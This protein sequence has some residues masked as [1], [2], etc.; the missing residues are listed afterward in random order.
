[1][2]KSMNRGPVMKKFLFL[3]FFSAVLP[4]FAA[5][6]GFKAD[7][8]RPADNIMLKNGAVIQDG[9]LRFFKSRSYAE[10]VESVPYDFRNG[11]TLMMVCRINDLAS[12]PDKYRFLASKGD[13]FLFG[14]TNQKYNF[15]FCH[16]N[17]WSIAL[18]GGTPPKEGEWVHLAAVARRI[19]DKEQGKFG[20]QL[21]LYVN[22]ERILGKFAPCGELNP[23]KTAPIIIGTPNSGTHVMGD[24]S[25]VSFT[26]RAL[27]ANEIA[28][29]ALGNKLIKVTVPGIFELNAD[30]VQGLASLQKKAL[31]P[32]EKFIA[33][34]LH[35]AAAAGAPQDKVTR[36]I[37]AAEKL[38]SAKPGTD[39]ERIERFNGSQND[40]RLLPGGDAIL[41]LVTG[42]GGK[43]FPV[44][45]MY[46][47]RA[48]FGVFGMRSN[49]W[50]LRYN[51][52]AKPN[53]ELND[54]SEN[55]NVEI[56][57]VVMKDGIFHF[58]ILWKN[59]Q[60]EVRSDASF[61]AKGLRMNLNAKALAKDVKLIECK[62]PQWSLAHKT[63]EDFLV[64]PF[65]SGLQ[66]PK[67]IENYSNERDYPC[68]QSSMQFH[69]YFSSNGDGVYVALEDPDATTRTTAVFGCRKQLGVTW[70][71][72][73]PYELNSTG[74]NS[75]SL[76]SDTVIRLYQ[77]GWFEAGQLYKEFLAQRAS[78]WI[79][80]LPRR[81]TPEWFRN[82]SIWIL[83]GVNPSRNEA[84][85]HYLRTYFDQEF[86]VHLVGTTQHRRWPH[87]D[88]TTKEGHRL[89]RSL[90]SVGL[91]VSPYSDPRLW[92]EV[93]PDGS[94][95]W[96]AN[97]L[98][99]AVKKEN[100]SPQ[101]ESYGIDCLVLC[102]ASEA[103]HGEYLRIC[104][105]IASQGFNGIY[106]DQ[107]PC[108]HAMPCFDP[109]HGHALNDPAIWV[110]DGYA[111]M[112]RKLH[113]ALDKKYPQFV[114]TGEDAS[115]PF[116]KMID[117]Y[118]CWRWTEPN[119]IP[120]FQSIYAGR[121]QF[122]GKLYN[123][124][125]PGDWESN[126]AKAASQAVNGE[127]LGWITLEDLEAA[128][129]FRKYFKTLAWI[130]R[131][132]LEYFNTAD[133]VAPLKFTSTPG[134]MY[135]FWGN[136]SVD[137]LKVDSDIIQHSVW[138]LPDGRIMVLF[139][140]T[141]ERIQKAE[142]VLPFSR[143][144]FYV[145]RQ[146][147]PNPLTAA[148]P[149]VLELP[150]YGAEIWLLSSKDNAAEAEKIASLLHKTSAFDEGKTLNL[151]AEL[152]RKVPP[153]QKVETTKLI[154]VKAAELCTN[155]FPRYFANGIDKDT[156][157]I[158][159]DG[160]RICYSGL[161]FEKETAKIAII[162]AFDRSETAGRFEIFSKGQKIGETI[163]EKGGRYLDFQEIPV[164]LKGKLSG[165]DNDIE[166]VFRGKSCRFKGWKAL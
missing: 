158:L 99:M 111:K 62:F 86:G 25:E 160:S 20:F 137:G 44:V 146:D 31:A 26:D 23:G 110:K 5:E 88:L 58:P 87:F 105:A 14:L 145:C 51:A 15:S 49:T 57:P 10:V 12:N 114:H 125:Y 121:I 69:G 134:K 32:F 141:T 34:S 94:K 159:Y 101:S 13:S 127:Q 33:D 63:G 136:T 107:L 91:K 154:S 90:Q 52:G 123:H 17:R 143:K 98:A 9:Q 41:F 85:L 118:T 155:T 68:A 135:S 112:Y 22:G 37:R 72:A 64:T 165:K 139:L 78:W 82:N 53:L 79:P 163:L 148:R 43:A 100:Q 151:K 113:E 147:T 61:S 16:D 21:E 117:G 1:M 157:L 84:T 30:L 103:W 3:S 92:A 80:E 55:M 46:D 74:G 76:G 24:F 102:P 77:G 38:F 11:G 156:V 67:P 166:I 140:N 104:S 124:Q 96:P 153:E 56:G 47:V 35:K 6:S 120:L 89:T 133:R 65:M 8:S 152:R 19:A 128:T 4:M 27:S 39:A 162:T 142:P 60:I 70:K 108:G 28:Q 75:F 129:P 50:N 83:A 164:D 138:Q 149:P 71:T 115:D 95:G 132:L 119:A 81:S 130:R 93:N 116:L 2:N 97:A 42:E 106:H 161:I 109:K 131:S 144:F 73:C 122:T 66:I 18:I 45:D 40:F 36:G 150:P 48:K 29:A 54:Y 126:F 7:F 59:P